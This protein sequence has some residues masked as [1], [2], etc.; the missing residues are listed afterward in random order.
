MKT[1]FKNGNVAIDGIMT[2]TDFCVDNEKFDFSLD[3]AD[4]VIDL[5]GAVVLPSIFD[6]HTHGANGYDFNTA[7]ESGIAKIIEFYRKNGVGGFLA[8]VM[9]DS[10]ENM[11]R[12]LAL[13]ASL[14]KKYP[15]IVGIHLEGPF[16]SRE[17]KGAMNEKYLL[18]PS[19]EVF[20]K[21]F[22][23]AQGNVRLI[24]VSPELIGA[25]MLT[26]HA[27]ALGVT[28]SLG[29]SGANSADV[30][31]CINCG[32]NGFTHTFNAMIPFDHHKPNI[33]LS[34][35]VSGCYAE[36]I[37][38]GKHL[39]PDVVKLLLK[40][41]GDKL[42]LI[43]DS[44]MATGLNDGYYSLGGSP[45]AVLGGEA[46]LKGTEVRAGSTLSA[47]DGLRN[48]AKFCGLDLAAAIRN[49]SI[50]P[51]RYLGLDGNYGSITGGKLADFFVISRGEILSVYERG[52]KVYE[53]TDE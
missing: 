6:I 46:F 35:M 21:L 36:A 48:F 32:A 10:M 51:Y 5:D 40:V 25:D 52:T 28:V 11:L 22:A 34:A 29:H 39:A 20:D 15:I 31:R 53:K 43:T 42:C 8:T 14:M 41:K 12:Q 4:N 2:T 47:F 3:N 37:V 23:A 9:T 45:V 50:I 1:I 19:V 26:A 18:T 33:S 24:T 38:D 16:L 13:I 44:I 49:F 27:S 17:Y 30:N 7:D